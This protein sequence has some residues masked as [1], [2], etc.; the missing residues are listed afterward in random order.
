MND[1]IDFDGD[2]ASADWAKQTWDL[3][4]YKS[5]AF[6]QVIPIEQ[7]PDFRNRPVYQ[8]AVDQGLIHDDEWVA[9]FVVA[10][11]TDSLADDLLSAI[12]RAEGDNAS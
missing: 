1:V 4:P 6:F 9:N 5:D 10:S 3:P 12:K 8:H 2:L 11:P 7:L